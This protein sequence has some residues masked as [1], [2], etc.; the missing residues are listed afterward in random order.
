V[1]ATDHVAERLAMTIA[2]EIGRCFAE[3]L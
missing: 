1:W 3:C 2:N